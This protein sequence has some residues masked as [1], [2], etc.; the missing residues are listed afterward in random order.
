MPEPADNPPPT[1]E[2]PTPPNEWPTW[3]VAVIDRTLGTVDV[4]APT[5]DAARA[6]VERYLDHY[7]DDYQACNFGDRLSGDIILDPDVPAEETDNDP[8]IEWDPE[9]DADAPTP[10]TPGDLKS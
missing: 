7:E 3:S 4:R 6:R 5:A 2:P 1:P 9:E 8:D 10:A